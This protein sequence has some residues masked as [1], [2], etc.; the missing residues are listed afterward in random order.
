MSYRS[1]TRKYRRCL[2]SVFILL[3]GSIL[4]ST[5]GANASEPRPL[6]LSIDA[7]DIAR[8]LFHSEIS[9][10]VRPGPLTLA[11]P[12]WIPG[13]HAPV[14]PLNNI[15]RLKI[16]ANGQH[17]TWKRDAVETFNFHIVVPTDVDVVTVVMDVVAPTRPFVD[18]GQATAQL[19]VLEWNQVLL[20]PAEAASDDLPVRAR[21]RLPAG[22]KYGC[23]LAAQLADAGFLEFPQVSLTTL[24]DSPVLSG[25]Y[26]RTLQF[27][28]GPAPPVLVDIAAD[29]PEGT[30]IPAAW[31]ARFHCLI[32]ETRALFGN[33]PYPEYHFLISLSDELGDDGVEHL[34]SSDNRMGLRMFSDNAYRLSYAYLLP[35]EYVHAW[36]GKYRRPAGLATRN[37]QEPQNGELLWVYEG[38]TRYLNWVLAARSGIL[39]PEEARDYAALLA[40]LMDHR[41]GREW[42]SLQD[43]AISGQFLYFAPSEWQSLRRSVDYYDESLFIWLEADAI[44]RRQ[45]Q[46]KRSLD[47]F[48]RTFFKPPNQTP[49]VKTYSYDDVVAALHG[50]AA[51]DWDHFFRTRLDSTGTDRAPLDGLT[52]SGWDL[53]YASAPNSVESARDQIH[54][55][56]EERFSLGLLLQEDGSITDVVRDSPAWKAGLGPGMKLLTVN[57][58]P[59]SAQ[60]LRD[61]IAEDVAPSAPVILS[62]KNGLV[63]FTAEVRDRMGPQYPH[64][65]RNA[66]PDGMNDILAPRVQTGEPH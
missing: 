41:S 13:Y 26:F 33:V 15:V 51:Y 59:W 54:Q 3:L 62:V 50:I 65:Q 24:V 43:T 29:T 25:K 22:W 55:T 2:D 5:S 9:I 11:Y 46:G 52:A 28:S 56:I 61:A 19:F 48:C 21:L 36:N 53:S 58:H 38:L 30:E 1:A 45:T 6:V 37:Y 12:K 31:Q 64:L 40:A 35:H 20:Y 34:A 60:A 27:K 10:P 14:G 32:D 39:S 42:R 17:L 4:V 66:H 57:Q 23:A 8:K 18:P 7:T 44:L 16:S 47:D 63:T 49:T